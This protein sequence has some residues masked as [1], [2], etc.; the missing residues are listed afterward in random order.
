MNPANQTAKLILPDEREISLP[1]VQG[2]AGF[3]GIDTSALLPK[4]RT[5]TV[6]PGYTSTAAVKSAITYIDPEGNGNLAVLQYRGIPIEVLAEKSTPLETAYLVYYGKLP[7]QTELNGFEERIAKL[8]KP[9]EIARNHIAALPREYHPMGMLGSAVNI[10][11]V[12]NGINQGH[13]IEEFDKHA[14][15]LIAQI[16]TLC[17]WVHAHRAGLPLLDPDL[18]L[19]YGDRYLD[20]IFSDRASDQKIHAIT[21]QVMNAILIL[22]E[23]HEQNASTTAVRNITSTGANLYTAISGGIGSLWGPLHG[24]ANEA[25]ITMLHNAIQKGETVESLIEHAK[26]SKDPKDRLMGIGHRVYKAVD[27]RAGVIRKLCAQ[28]FEAFGTDSKE[29]EFALKLEKAVLQDSYFHDRKLYPNVDFYSG[30]LMQA[31]GIKPEEFTT[32]FV[33][34]RVPGWL[35]HAREHFL[36]PQKKISR[37]RQIYTGKVNA[38]YVSIEERT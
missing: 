20:L 38:D 11:S 23:D 3:D 6:D 28:Y 15:F 22:H 34:G 14:E 8:G 10:L 32:I 29:L 19:S 12:V 9:I 13:T 5:V 16:P 26:G 25:V 7:T 36:D 17:A 31:M 33:F 35:A 18:S 21:S 27:P 1:F 37:P 30:I 24:G 4:H 2:T